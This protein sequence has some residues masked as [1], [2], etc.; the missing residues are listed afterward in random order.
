M[1]GPGPNAAAA[2]APVVKKGLLDNYDDVEGYY[3]F[4]VRPASQLNHNALW[5]SRP[6]GAYLPSAMLHCFDVIRLLS[7]PASSRCNRWPAYVSALA[8]RH[9]L[10]RSVCLYSLSL[11]TCQQAGPCV[12][13]LLRCV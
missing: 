11:I 5:S 9:C 12:L 1:F 10:S 8:V 4:Q 13:M 2:G 7:V 3:N 6:T